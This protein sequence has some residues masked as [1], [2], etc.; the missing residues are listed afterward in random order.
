M[1]GLRS[2][3]PVFLFLM[4]IPFAAANAGPPVDLGG[5]INLAWNNCITQPSA[6]EN[7]DYACDGSSNGTPYKLVASFISLEDL[8]AF[9]GVQLRFDIALPAG[10]ANSSDPLPDWWRAAVGEC[11]EGNLGFPMSFSG[12]GTG[13][14]GACQNPYAGTSAGA[15]GMT[16]F[17]N[18]GGNSNRAHINT[19]SAIPGSKLILGNQQYVAGVFT[20]DTYRDV[21]GDA[22]TPCTGCGQPMM[23]TL[24]R[25]ELYQI[26][27]THNDIQYLY[28]PETRNT[29][30]WQQSS[31]NT[32]LPAK[33]TTWGSIKA[34]YR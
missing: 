9:V 29:V 5:K 15:A 14:T 30:S 4:G 13:T 22:G 23:I 21:A 25:V 18:Y 8:P 10:H 2:S 1:K 32:P 27:G 16:Y 34:S 31:T 3:I 19:A 33:R 11:R 26:A 12:I 17:S 7:I 28:T 24:Y 6:G 20:L